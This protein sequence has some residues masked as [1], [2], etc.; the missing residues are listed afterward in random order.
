MKPRPGNESQSV[1]ELG[2]QPISNEQVVQSHLS[3]PRSEMKL[4]VM[5]PALRSN[6][7]NFV[8][9]EIEHT[10]AEPSIHSRIERT[11]S[12]NSTATLKKKNSSLSSY[13]SSGTGRLTRSVRFADDTLSD[14]TDKSQSQFTQSRYSPSPLQE[15]LRETVSQKPIVSLNNYFR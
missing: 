11:A 6:T 15:L 12:H 9:S 14:D 2:T 1:V 7:E 3:E 4:V 10:I 13:K 8:P 5:K